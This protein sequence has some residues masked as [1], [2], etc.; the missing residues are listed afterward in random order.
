MFDKRGTIDHIR[1][2]EQATEDW[3]RYQSI[4]L[5][6]LKADRDK[7]NMV[8]HAMLVAIQATIDIAN[9]LIAERSLSKPSTYPEGFQI[10]SRE[11]IIPAE[12]ANSLSDL[13]GF[14]NVL[15]H[16]YWGL[17]LDEVHGMLASELEVIEEFRKKAVEEVKKSKPAST[18]QT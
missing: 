9:H 1:M 18:K 16:V 5:E 7:Q 4:P 2:L 12:L 13:A 6:E 17:N 11:G 15:V 10:L 14:R 8:L 3:K